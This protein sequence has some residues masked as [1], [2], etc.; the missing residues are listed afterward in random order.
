MDGCHQFS[1]TWSKK[2]A[3]IVSWHSASDCLIKI[4]HVHVVTFQDKGGLPGE[5]GKLYYNTICMPQC[6]AFFSQH[7]SH[8]SQFCPYFSKYTFCIK[9][10]MLIT[11]GKVGHF[12]VIFFKARFLFLLFSVFNLL[13][14]P[15]FLCFQ[16]AKRYSGN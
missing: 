3:S 11:G 16:Y 14:V 13:S 10:L 5:Q 12:A 8:D 15:L 4:K 6:V 2:E 7:I 9:W 1:Y